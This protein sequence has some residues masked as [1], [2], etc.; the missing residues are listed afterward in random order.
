MLFKSH[1]PPIA[2]RLLVA[3][4]FTLGFLATVSHSESQASNSL[5]QHDPPLKDDPLVPIH[6][7]RLFD[8]G[9]V[10]SFVPS[11]LG[12]I[13]PDNI[14]SPLVAQVT[15][16]VNSLLPLL[17]NPSAQLPDGVTLVTGGQAALPLTAQ[18]LPTGAQLGGLADKLGGLLNGV[19]PVAAPSIIAKITEKAL[20]VVASVEAIA[21][22]VASLG[23]QIANHQIQAPDALGQIGGLLGSLDSKVNDIVNGITSDLSS[24]LPLPVLKDLGQAIS[25]GL[26]DV[27]GA[28]N[29][30]L[31]LVGDLIEQNV[32]GAVTEVDGILATVAGL[33]GEMPSAVAE[34]SSE[35]A[36]AHLTNSDATLTGDASAV[37]IFPSSP[38]ITDNSATASALPSSPQNSRDQDTLTSPATVK[39][40][41]S[42]SSNPEGDNAT[43][44]PGQQSPSQATPGSSISNTQTPSGHPSTGSPSPGSTG[45]ASSTP[46]SSLPST[47]ASTP[48]VNGTQPHSTAVSSPV[49]AGSAQPGAGSASQTTATG[50][51]G[52]VTVTEYQTTC[53]S[54]VLKPTAA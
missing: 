5:Q 53:T 28:A 47:G 40:S 18:P 33:C 31:P 10:V 37:T 42:P 2:R 45:G 20:G 22:D 1:S 14:V 54:D 16:D 19:V 51:D 23:G 36:T 48:G 41:D 49:T 35:L 12:N 3:T 4:L 21:T 8:W 50:A 30:P 34:V 52:I 9:A 26:G 38:P 27:I 39:S 13:V 43:S 6:E 44:S 15:A 25:S 11:L 24:E 29:G 32:C 46:V 7:K 17:N